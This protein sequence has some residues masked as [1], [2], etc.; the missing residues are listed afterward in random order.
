MKN[1]MKKLFKWLRKAKKKTIFRKMNSP[2]GVKALAPI[3]GNTF[4]GF[5]KPFWVKL[6]ALRYKQLW[7]LL[8]PNIN[9]SPSGMRQ[10]RVQC[11][12]WTPM[13]SLFTNWF[14]WKFNPKR[15]PLPLIKE[16]KQNGTGCEMTNR[17]HFKILN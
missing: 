8:S 4:E 17:G 3:R 14:Q 11:K 1:S 13:T 6:M 10:F 5:S 2:N 7:N 15:G 12:R 9:I 16:P